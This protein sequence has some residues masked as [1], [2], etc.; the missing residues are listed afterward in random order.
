MV[1]MMNYTPSLVD[2]KLISR[3]KYSMKNTIANNQVVN[4]NYNND[5]FFIFLEFIKR[6]IGIFFITIFL[7]IVLYL[8]Y[9]DV[10]KKKMEYSMYNLYKLNSI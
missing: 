3:L 1:Y 10:Q 6:N 7:G 2:E 4:T 8:R 9:Q 5:Y